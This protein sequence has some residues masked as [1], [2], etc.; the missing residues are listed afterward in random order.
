MTELNPISLWPK[1]KSELQNQISEA[2]YNTYLPNLELIEVN[3]HIVK[4]TH[5]YSFMLNQI[6]TKF[7]QLIKTLLHQHTG[8]HFQLE[9]I[10]P[11]EKTAKNPVEDLPLFSPQTTR[12]TQLHQTLHRANLLP[13]FTFDNFAVGSTNQFAYAAAEA[14]ARQP[15][16]AY[17]PLFIYGNT[18]VGKS[19]LMQAIG[20][21]ILNKE[22]SQKILFCPGENFTNEIIAAIR[23]KTTL[24]FKAKYRQM[25]AL[26][27]DDVQFLA[28]KDTAQE[29]FFHTF[30][31]IHRAGGQIIMTADRSPV[32]LT[33][34]E[35]RLRSRFQA[36]LIVDIGEP[37]FELRTAILLIKSQMQSIDLPMEYAQQAAGNLKTARELEGFLMNL[38]SRLMQAGSKL[39]NSLIAEIL[40]KQIREEN[41]LPAGIRP[42]D[43]IKAAADFF[44]LKINQIKGKSRQARIVRARHIAQHIMRAELKIQLQSIGEYFS[45]D[46]TTIMH[47]VEKLQ[48]LLG[49]TPELDQQIIGIKK[50]LRG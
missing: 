43:I 18:G 27:L 14:V 7:S 5:K 37:D 47:A 1:I 15:G 11:E 24:K 29:E 21:A 38:K 2:A 40:S 6:D 49:K 28:G 4:F 36:G 34:L 33:L 46:H 41:Q 26:L 19:H 9:Y 32:E 35:D 42:N 16:Q 25:D 48:K 44:D 3:N 17:N 31:A 10:S 8:Q 39:D 45:R 13:H 30:N 23:E 20:H 12:Q 50:M 22:P